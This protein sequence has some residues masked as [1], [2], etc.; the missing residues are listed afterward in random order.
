VFGAIAELLNRS[1]EGGPMQSAPPGFALSL[2]TAI[3]EAAINEV[4]RDSA[5]AEAGLMAESRIQLS[6]VL[7][8]GQWFVPA[9][10][11]AAGIG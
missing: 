10:P 11:Q 5:A 8:A 1:R 3:D 4:T 6:R 9:C 7:P 2:V